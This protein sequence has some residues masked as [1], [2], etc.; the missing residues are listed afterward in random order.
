MA[1]SRKPLSD[2][3]AASLREQL[4]QCGVGEA[5]HVTVAL[6]GGLD[7]IVLL[8][9]ANLAAQQLHFQLSAIH[10]NHQ[11]QAQAEDWVLFCQR[12]CESM[13]I[14]LSI[15]TLQLERQGGESLEAVARA[16]RYSAFDA[17]PADCLLLAQHADDQAETLL[18]QLLRGAGVRGLA[19]MPAQQQRAGKIWLRPLLTH[20]RSEIESYARQNKLSWIEDPSNANCDFD[21]NFLRHD[22][23]PSLLE[24]FPALLETFGRTARHMAEA[25]YLLDSYAAQ[26]GCVRGDWLALDCWRLLV[27][28]QRRNVLRYWLTLHGMRGPSERRLQEIS[29]Q[30]LQ[31][32]PDSQLNIGL[33]R[34]LSL[35][36]YRERAWLVEQHSLPAKNFQLGWSGEPQ[37]ELPAMAGCLAFSSAMGRGVRASLLHGQTVTIRFRQGGERLCLSN[38]RPGKSLQH[39]FQEK[40]IPPW[41]RDSLPLVYAGDRLV[42][43]AGLGVAASCV[44]GPGEAGFEIAHVPG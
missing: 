23:L 36:R 33:E 12:V 32:R 2:S 19:A 30:L 3:L 34:G 8:H 6:S 16:G 44:A 13:R 27:A 10:I 11:L 9:L 26:T 40:G 5:R 35:R 15:V 4:L 25:Q 38:D 39:W 14:P 28:E 7:S 21:R 18:L 29:R 22:V 41:Q 31:S 43:V 37:L 42:W 24:R 1:N 17:C 20:T